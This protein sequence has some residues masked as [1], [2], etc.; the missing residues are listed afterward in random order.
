MHR[1]TGLLV[2]GALAVAVSV[3]AAGPAVAAKGG[4]NDTAKRCQQGGWKM[5]V[6]QTGARFKNQGDCVNDGAHG[7]GVQPAPNEDPQTV[8]LSLPNGQY[9]PADQDKQ[10]ECSWE[11]PPETSPELEQLCGQGEGDWNLEVS[12][13]IADGV[14]LNR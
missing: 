8:C 4:N 9:T 11:T 12:G 7:L 3:V 6:S 14:C 5:L 1:V 2:V 10:F 13:G